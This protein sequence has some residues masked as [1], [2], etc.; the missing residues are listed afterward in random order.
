MIFQAS[1]LWTSRDMKVGII[2]KVLLSASSP[3][4]TALSTL[5]LDWVQLSPSCVHRGTGDRVSYGAWK[6]ICCWN[7]PFRHPQGRK[8]TWFSL[9]FWQCFI[10]AIG[11]FCIFA[12]VVLT[13]SF[14]HLNLSFWLFLTVLVCQRDAFPFFCLF[15]FQF[16]VDSVGSYNSPWG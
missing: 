8:K 7:G 16:Y 9:Q 2:V 15:F 10:K 13:P 4:T 12:H 5:G 14:S 3:V 1:Y 11:V 6:D